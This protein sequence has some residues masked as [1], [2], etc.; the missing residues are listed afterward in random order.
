MKILESRFLQKGIFWWN[1]D[2]EELITVTAECD[3]EGNSDAEFNAK[4]G[5]TY[6]HK[7]SW[8]DLKNMYR[9]CRQHS[10]NYYPRGRVIISRGT[11]DVYWNIHC[12][13]AGL[14]NDIIQQFGLGCHRDNIRWHID[15]SDHYK[16]HLDDSSIK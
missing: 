14:E 2:A 13:E 12:A 10:Y 7:K 8:E 5:D 1:T 9:C 15:R 3:L 11:I 6:N 4:S 16:C